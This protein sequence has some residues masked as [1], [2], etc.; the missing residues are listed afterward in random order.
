[1]NEQLPLPLYRA[2]T[3]TYVRVPGES[4]G[5][6][7]AGQGKT[8]NFTAAQVAVLA[9]TS[10]RLRGVREDGSAEKT[11]KDFGAEIG[12]SQ[13][14]I[15]RLE[16]GQGC[17]YQVATRLAH[18]AGV[19]GVDELFRQHGAE[20]PRNDGPA[21]D[22]ADRELVRARNIARFVLEIPQETIDYV[23]RVAG[24]PMTEMPMTEWL[25]RFITLFDHSRSIASPPKKPG[26]HVRNR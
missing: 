19:A 23:V 9:S 25:A 12:A 26:S 8:E 11:M 6:A 10:K 22:G 7:K 2:N 4:P 24:G 18:R 13:Q 1:M 3:R 14:T 21:E 15:S 5:V 17:G 16:L 20:T